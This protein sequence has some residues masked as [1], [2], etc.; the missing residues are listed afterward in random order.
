[1]RLEAL[2]VR[3]K[4]ALA[5]GLL[6]AALLG[7]VAVAALALLAAEGLLLGSRVRAQRPLLLTG[8]ALA[9]FAALNGLLVGTTALARWGPLSLHAEGLAAGAVFTLRALCAASLGLWLLRTT[10]PRDALRLLHRRPRWAVVAAGTMR[11]APLVALD[12]QRVRE[13]QTLRGHGPG[14]GLRGVLAAAPLVV[15]LFILAVRRGVAVD[16]ALQASAFGSGPR[17]PPLR[18]ALRAPDAAVMGCGAALLLL[19]AARA[20][21]LA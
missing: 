21:G 1:M 15:P 4:L 5:A 8:V 19:A 16:E 12:W 6:A 14:K 7:D 11:F 3:A 2:D 18:R 10:P 17:T 20:G 9:P 13:A